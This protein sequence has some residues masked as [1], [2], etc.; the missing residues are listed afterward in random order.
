MGHYLAKL[1][2]PVKYRYLQYND[3]VAARAFSLADIQDDN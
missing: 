1:G 3:L 2:R